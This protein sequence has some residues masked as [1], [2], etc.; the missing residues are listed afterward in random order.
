MIIGISLV[1]V[2]LALGLCLRDRI[3]GGSVAALQKQEVSLDPAT[4]RRLE[5]RGN[6]LNPER[7]TSAD[8]A[9]INFSKILEQ[10]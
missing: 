5:A 9:G 6:G 3:N 4:L 2:C 1:F 10:A 7:L 8:V